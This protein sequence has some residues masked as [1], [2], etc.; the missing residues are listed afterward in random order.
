MFSLYTG[1]P[2]QDFLLVHLDRPVTHLKVIP[3][4]PPNKI[5]INDNI[6]ATLYGFGGRKYSYTE[7]TSLEAGGI[8][9]ETNLAIKTAEYCHREMD[10][11]E[12]KVWYENYLPQFSVYDPS[13]QNGFTQGWKFCA[14]S[15]DQDSAACYGD[16]GS[17]LVYDVKGV[18]YVVGVMSYGTDCLEA[19]KW[20]EENLPLPK[21]L[22]YYPK[23]LPKASVFSKVDF[24]NDDINAIIEKNGNIKDWVVND[25]K[26]QD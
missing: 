1:N 26:D 24:F 14:E 21:D 6:V 15:P 22:K 4:S 23:N 17:P 19:H 7:K 13:D 5:D 2:V 9:Q 25:L 10:T 3:I 11:P 8:L 18:L 16:S 20:R 12:V